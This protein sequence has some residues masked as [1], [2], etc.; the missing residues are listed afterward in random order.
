MSLLL[1]FKDMQKKG[2][3][4]RNFR[5]QLGEVNWKYSFLAYLEFIVSKKAIRVNLG[6][7]KNINNN[8]KKSYGNIWKG[9]IN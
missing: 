5:S 3:K 8:L 4:K 1:H 6:L 7:K 2:E 9:K